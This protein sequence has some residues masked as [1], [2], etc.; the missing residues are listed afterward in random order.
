MKNKEL[1]SVMLSGLAVTGGVLAS[2]ATGGT[3]AIPLLLCTGALSAFSGIGGNLLSS[4]LEKSFISLSSNDEILRNDDLTRAIG[5][6]I[7]ILISDESTKA[8]YGSFREIIKSVGQSKDDEW[9][10][11]LEE[12]LSSW[13]HFVEKNIDNET[14]LTEENKTIYSNLEELLPNQLT[15][16][17]KP[18]EGKFNDVVSLTP[19]TWALIVKGLFQSQTYQPKDEHCLSIG[20]RLYRDFP[21]T[22]RK[23]LIDDFSQDGK[24]YASM[25]F[26]I[27]GEVLLYSEKNKELSTEILSNIKSMKATIDLI[28]ER[29]SKESNGTHEEFW[30]IHIT[31][32]QEFVKKQEAQISISRNILEENQEQTKQGGKQIEQNEEQTLVLKEMNENLILNIKQQQLQAGSFIPIEIDIEKELLKKVEIFFKEI[33]SSVRLFLTHHPHYE[34][35]DFV[36][37]KFRFEIYMKKENLN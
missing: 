37:D 28:F 34:K 11:Y 26:Q 32:F 29:F 17:I 20:E 9:E 12:S 16:Y 24:A 22:L 8:K 5:K 2:V 4:Y 18:S 30:E 10:K 23:I 13:K 7:F 6:T 21:S 14:Q 3:A 27:L 1:T 15:T 31:F 36:L 25:Q 19:E 35:K 33:K